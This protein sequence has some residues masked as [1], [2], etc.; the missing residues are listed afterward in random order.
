MK[1]LFF[2][3][4]HGNQYTIRKLIQQIGKINIDLIVFGGDLFGYY[5]GQKEIISMLKNMNCICLMGNHDRYFLDLYDGKINLCELERKYGCSYRDSLDILDDHDIDFIR[6]NFKYFYETDIDS[7]HL[8]FVHGSLDDNLEGR[9]Y[10]DTEVLNCE[11]YIGFD[12]VFYG[13]TH[14]KTIKKIKNGTILVN[15]G[16]IGQQRDGKGCTYVVFDSKTKKITFYNVD[17]N[18]PSLVADIKE[19]QEDTSLEKKL[20]EVLYRNNKI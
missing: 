14:H 1:I 19:H 11:K 3:D 15:P 18:I 10:P 12:Y 9:I 17:Y 2:S 5:Y 16:S 4:A 7:L 6:N 20:I 13:H 8:L